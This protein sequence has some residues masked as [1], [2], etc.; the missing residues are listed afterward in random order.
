MITF[1]AAD[2]YDTPIYYKKVVR[3][4]LNQVSEEW[5]DISDWFQLWRGEWIRV[6]PG[7]RNSGLYPIQENKILEVRL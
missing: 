6:G 5:Q 7:F 1:W 3:K 4:H 2:F